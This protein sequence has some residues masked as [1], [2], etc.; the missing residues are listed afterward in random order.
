MVIG[1]HPRPTTTDKSSRTMPK[2]PKMVVTAL[3]RRPAWLTVLQ[4][5]ASPVKVYSVLVEY[6]KVSVAD[7]LTGVALGDGSSSGCSSDGDGLSGRRIVISRSSGRKESEEREDE[8]SD[9]LGEHCGEWE[10]DVVRLWR[11]NWRN[12]L[13]TCLLL[14]FSASAVRHSLS[15]S[16]P[17]RPGTI[18]NYFLNVWER[19]CYQDCTEYLCGMHSPIKEQTDLPFRGR[20]KLLTSTEIRECHLVRYSFE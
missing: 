3:P 12:S 9:N 7:K 20:R 6:I 5:W 17:S 14:C 13:E 2:R 10:I 16:S 11:L 19:Y 18:F 15:R 1:V 4:H 8:K